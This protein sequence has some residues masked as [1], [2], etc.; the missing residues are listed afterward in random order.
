MERIVINSCGIDIMIETDIGIK[1]FIEKNVNK[2]NFPNLKVREAREEEE[3]TKI[4]QYI[5]QNY[6]KRKDE[7]KYKELIYLYILMKERKNNGGYNI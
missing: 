4:K 1:E 7:K 3:N 5:I 6:K 2:T